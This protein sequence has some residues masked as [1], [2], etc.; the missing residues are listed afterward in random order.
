M[1]MDEAAEP[2]QRTTDNGQR[3][4]RVVTIDGPAGAGKS[5]VARL[6]AARLGWRFLDTGAMFRA[7]TLAA[8]GSGIDLVDER[9][10]KALVGAIRV[11]LLPD[12]V[13]LD[14]RDITRD[15][16]SVEVTAASRYVADSPAVRCVL[17][18]WQRDFARAHNVV[19]EGRDQGTLVFPDA[20]R[21]F[22][23]TATDEER[24][25]RRLAD[26]QAKGHCD[27]VSLESVLHE[28]RE[29]DARDA[30]RAIAPMK[31]APDAVVIDSSGMS[32]EQVVMALADDLERHI[33]K[34]AGHAA[35]R[36][37]DAT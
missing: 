27:G 37:E 8:L 23:L 20:F 29:R 25:R 35:D 11:T 4:R 26:Y 22:Y 16:R 31:P 32:I 36:A 2:E 7:V 10:L 3:T 9:E 28:I 24:A 15:I 30:G 19:T 33:R 13:L 6:L 14:G 21:K 34:S 18:E 1:T 12:A 5:T 17:K